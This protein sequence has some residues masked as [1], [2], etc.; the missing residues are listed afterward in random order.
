MDNKDLKIVTTPAGQLGTVGLKKWVTNLLKF[1]AP[2][3]LIYLGYVYL[4]IQGNGFQVT[5]F[6]PDQAVIGALM[7]W[8]LNAALDFFR[9]LTTDQTYVVPKKE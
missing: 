3:A 9:K 2:L 8:I 6:V 5:D 7:L 1:S 4:Q